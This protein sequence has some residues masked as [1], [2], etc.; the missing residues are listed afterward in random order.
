[1]SETSS[2]IASIKA[3]VRAALLRVD[4][5][6]MY[7]AKVV[8]QSGDGTLEVLPD[9]PRLP[10]ASNVPIRIGVPGVDVKVMPGARVM[11]GFDGG[12]PKA[13]FAALFDSSSLLAI[14]ITSATTVTIKA[15]AQVTIS[16]SAL[17]SV[18]APSV[19]LGPG[20]QPVAR[21]GDPVV[22]LSP[23]AAAVT[24][25]TPM[26]GTITAGNPAVLA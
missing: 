10:G 7:S 2:L 17:V 13:P 21:L 12:N 18:S 24:P 16:A 6:A 14:T 9:D 22:V 23:G 26:M 4:F 19:V 11:I 1:M 3:L 15:N 25:G 5:Y 20:G 8:A